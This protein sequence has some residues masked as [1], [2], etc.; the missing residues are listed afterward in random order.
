MQTQFLCMFFWTLVQ[1]QVTFT[2][3]HLKKNKKKTASF[4]QY[5]WVIKTLNI[6]KSTAKHI[7]IYDLS[8]CGHLF[9]E[10]RSA[11][12]LCLHISMPIN[13]CIWIVLLILF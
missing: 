10:L 5:S 9:S 13:A 8:P 11:D 12:T 1:C 3:M 2:R 7:Y 6:K 4:L